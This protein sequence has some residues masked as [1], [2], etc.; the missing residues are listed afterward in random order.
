[1]LSWKQRTVLTLISHCTSIQTK[2]LPKYKSPAAP[3]YSLLLCPNTTSN[4]PTLKS[5]TRHLKPRHLRL[6]ILYLAT[7]MSS[8]QSSSADSQSQPSMLGGHA[9][10]QKLLS[11]PNPHFCLG[12]SLSFVVSSS[13]LT[14]SPLLLHEN[15]TCRAQSRRPWATNR[16]N[17]QKT[18]QYKRC[19]TP[20]RPNRQILISKPPSPP[21]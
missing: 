2:Y 7:A 1:M 19:A 5:Q 8:D 11:C 20:R 3:L 10:V 14:L 6:L 15:S 21:S 18:L 13:R 4:L 9:K 17:R 16:A 12:D